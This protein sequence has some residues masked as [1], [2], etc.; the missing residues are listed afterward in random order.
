MAERRAIDL[1]SIS[2]D[3]S[4]ERSSRRSIGLRIGAAG[5]EVRAPRWV[6]MAVL[7]EA[8]RNKG[9]W[10]VRKLAQRAQQDCAGAHSAGAAFLWGPGASIAWL[11]RSLVLDPQ[12]HA[13][14]VVPEVIGDRLVWRCDPRAEASLIERHVQVWLRGAALREFA[15]RVTRFEGILGV[16]ASQVLLSNARTR[17]GSASRDGTIRL[18]W[19]LVRAHPD[20]IDYVV[21]HELAHLREMNH[22]PAFWALVAAV[23]PD[24]ALR[25]KGLREIA[26]TVLAETAH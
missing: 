19:R 2:V 24:V 3:Y 5:L 21:A 14:N 15:P 10:I 23:I 4:L 13:A 6:G 11:G 26:Q 8:L 16:R 20:L 9:A 18:N 25:R 12:E 7:E 22:G 17:W 1:G